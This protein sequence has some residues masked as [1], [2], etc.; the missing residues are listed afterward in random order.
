MRCLRCLP[1]RG[2]RC[3]GVA[4]QRRLPAI[5]PVSDAPSRDH[6]HGP[7]TRSRAP[8]AERAAAATTHQQL[9][10]GERD[11]TAGGE[12]QQSDLSAHHLPCSSS[13]RPPLPHTQLI[14]PHHPLLCS[15]LFP[16]P[17]AQTPPVS[18]SPPAICRSECPLSSCSSACCS[19]SA[20][21]VTPATPPAVSR[22]RR[23]RWALADRHLR[24]LHRLHTTVPLTPL[25]PHPLRSS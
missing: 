2:L 24:P 3:E 13:P 16:P 6:R 5:L 12:A 20:S 9:R 11:Q 19:P 22:A 14:L 18:A 10:E 23:S 8:E 17:T 21:P 7:V 4:A 15:L 1:R 25:P